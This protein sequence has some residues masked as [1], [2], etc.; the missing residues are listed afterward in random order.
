[1]FI[2]P[3]TLNIVS[4][5][6]HLNQS[7]QSKPSFKAKAPMEEFLKFVTEK[8]S[9]PISELDKFL[10]PEEVEGFFH[11]GFLN[12]RGKKWNVSPKAQKAFDAVYKDLTEKQIEIGRWFN[13]FIKK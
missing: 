9:G 4:K 11:I 1:M 10:E 13:N 6:N 12:K 7:N 8:K 5:S 2:N 3:I